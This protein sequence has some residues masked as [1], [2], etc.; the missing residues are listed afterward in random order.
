M[1]THVSNPILPQWIR[2]LSL[3]RY[4]ERELLIPWERNGSVSGILTKS[5]WSLGLIAKWRKDISISSS[6]VIFLPDFFCEA[7]LRVVRAIGCQV[8]FYPIEENGLANIAKLREMC[9]LN[10]PDLIVIVH[11]F[12]AANSQATQFR[13][14]ASVYKAW[15]I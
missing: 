3:R 8:V 14:I 6:P 5:T 9:S 10:R 1:L 7:A 2:M 4:S 12:G 11:F 15:L 13:E